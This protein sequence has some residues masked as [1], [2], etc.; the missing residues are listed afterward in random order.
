LV[1]MPRGSREEEVPPRTITYLVRDEGV[2]GSNP[3]TPTSFLNASPG[4]GA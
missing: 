3:A 2:A 4:Y 1:L